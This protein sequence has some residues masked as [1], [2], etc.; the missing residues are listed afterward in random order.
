M[1]KTTIYTVPYRRKRQG[2]TNYRVRLKLLQGKTPRLVIRKSLQN[3]QLQIIDYHPDGDKVIATAHTRELKK[4]GWTAPCGNTAAAY[5]CGKLL[6]Q[7]AKNCKQLIPDIG[8]YTSVQKSKRYA[9]IKGVKDS[10]IKVMCS[11]TTFPTQER[12][13]GKHIAT[14]AAQLKKQNKETYQKYF[15][16]YLKNNTDPET[17]PLLFKTVTNK[18]EKK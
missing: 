11:E 8:I 3:I 15:A 5:L 18:M 13:E 10:G 7:K 12:I 14:Y 17:L 2:R 4:Y 1:A 16:T 9:A 6:G